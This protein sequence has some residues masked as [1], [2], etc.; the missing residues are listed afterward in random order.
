MKNVEF[1]FALEGVAGKGKVFLLDC[2]KEVKIFK[3]AKII[4][5]AKVSWSDLYRLKIKKGTK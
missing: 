2:I 4:D 5:S 1:H 3:K